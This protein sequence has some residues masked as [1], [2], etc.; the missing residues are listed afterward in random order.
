[1]IGSRIKLLG[2]RQDRYERTGFAVQS[3]VSLIAAALVMPLARHGRR[4]ADA[5]RAASIPESV[6]SPAETGAREVNPNLNLPVSI[7]VR[8]SRSE[9]QLQPSP[10]R[11]LCCRTGLQHRP[12]HG[13]LPCSS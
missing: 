7:F 13:R 6:D 3:A 9:F 12:V 5:E 1:Q 2:G 4:H 11:D 10:N 8:I